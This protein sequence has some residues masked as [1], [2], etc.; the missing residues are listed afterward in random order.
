[1]AFVESREGAGC[2]NLHRTVKEVN[3]DIHSFYT[4]SPEGQI[5]AVLTETELT[6]DL[7]FAFLTVVIRSGLGALTQAKNRVGSPL[8]NSDIT[9]QVELGR[10]CVR[11]LRGHERAP[12]IEAGKKT[13]ADRLAVWRHPIKPS[14]SSIRRRKRTRSYGLAVC[15]VTRT[16]AGRDIPNAKG[17]MIEELLTRAEKSKI[18][19]K[20]ELTDRDL[21]KVSGGFEITDFSFDIEQTLNIGSQSTGAGPSKVTKK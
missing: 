15:K 13:L 19:P 11:F 2:P 7:V 21:E 4:V 5:L 14:A 3:A 8:K 9:A 12:S 18:Q 17:R 20:D 1:L 10:R 16:D 6:S